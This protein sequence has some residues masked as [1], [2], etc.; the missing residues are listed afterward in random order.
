MKYNERGTNLIY[1]NYPEDKKDIFESIDKNYFFKG[2]N[3]SYLCTFEET[4]EINMM[5]AFSGFVLVLYKRYA[6]VKN[7]D[8][9]YKNKNFSDGH[10][11]K[12][13]YKE[14]GYVLISNKPRDY[15]IH[16]WNGTLTRYEL[17][18]DSDYNRALNPIIYE[19]AEKALFSAIELSKKSD[20]L[21]IVAQWFDELDRH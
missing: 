1:Y 9:Q 3:F 15:F 7:G 6:V 2:N 21:Y 19:T 14:N 20:E 8:V 10:V 12:G 18:D 16:S 17:C 13:R 5:S 4:K 11:A